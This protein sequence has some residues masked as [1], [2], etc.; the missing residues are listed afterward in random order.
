MFLL[1]CCGHDLQVSDFK[2][3]LIRP[4]KI[5]Y[6]GPYE[7][8]GN[9]LTLI[10]ILSY[11]SH[12]RAIAMKLFQRKP[13]QEN[14]H[15]AGQALEDGPLPEPSPDTKVPW[16]TWRSLVLGAFVSIGGIVFGYDTGQISG[17]LEM[18]NFKQR[19]GQRRPSGEYYFSNVRSGL[20]VG[21]VRLPRSSI[22]RIQTLLI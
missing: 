8:I 3:Q 19:Y 21:M 14:K 1:A 20:I 11:D 4:N 17:F 10:L 9:V 12:T 18:D 6:Q 5:F 22:F 7:R 13:V 16:I 2:Y 15:D